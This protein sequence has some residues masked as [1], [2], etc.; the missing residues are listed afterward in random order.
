[1]QEIWKTIEEFPKYEVSNK[2]RVRNIKTGRILKYGKHLKG[3]HQVNLGGTNQLVHRLVAL[4]FL[5]N[6]SETV[7]H[8]DGIKTNN[9]VNNLEWC[10]S[11]ENQKHAWDTGL[12]DG[13]KRMC[14]D[15]R[16]GIY[17]DT[18]SNFSRAKEV[19][20]STL[21]KHLVNI[22]DYGFDVKYV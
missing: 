7:N 22:K 19:S 3:Y 8:K 21:H 17:Y 20:R 6:K 15:L 11:A 13:R 9:Y 1:M 12:Y 10:T 16:T 2:G 4:T 5:P 18:A 14:L